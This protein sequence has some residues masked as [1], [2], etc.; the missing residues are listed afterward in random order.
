MIKVA[1][2]NKVFNKNT[3]LENINFTINDGQIAVIY[4][5]NGSGKTT[6][7]KCLVG[8]LKSENNGI[9]F[10]GINKSQISLYLGHE[11]LINSL[12]AYEYLYLSAVLKNISHSDIEKKILEFSK[13]L[14]FENYLNQYISKLSF[15]TKSKILFTVATIN[16]PKILIMDEP[17]IGIDLVTLEKLMKVLVELKMNGCTILI[18]SN[19]VEFLESII[20]K[21]LIL[22]DNKILI[23]KTIEDLSIQNFKQL[24]NM[25]LT[26]LK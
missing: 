7:I 6:L 5:L 2:L 9:E 22:K 15:G 3:V 19:Q 25:I 12:T 16:N 11:M 4:G 21:V 20:D 13:I 14:N 18:S 1:N 26:H 24:S 23:D 10:D 17:F 8:L